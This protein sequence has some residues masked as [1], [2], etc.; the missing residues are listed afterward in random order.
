MW[1]VHRPDQRRLRPWALVW[2][3]V[4]DSAVIPSPL[5]RPCVLGPCHCH[6]MAAAGHVRVSCAPGRPTVLHHTPHAHWHVHSM[7]SHIDASPILPPPAHPL[8]VC[9]TSSLRGALAATICSKQPAA[10]W[11]TRA[12]VAVHLSATYIIPGA[13]PDAATVSQIISNAGCSATAVPERLLV[14]Q[15]F[16]LPPLHARPAVLHQRD[17]EDIPCHRCVQS[18]RAASC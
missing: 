3:L 8:P 14:S 17:D 16:G 15:P 2:P 5:P 18:Q 13:P 4:I 12:C 11:R 1:C 7:V 9:C 10:D 6:C